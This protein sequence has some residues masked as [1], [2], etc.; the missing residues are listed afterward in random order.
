MDC[1]FDTHTNKENRT[2]P[3]ESMIPFSKWYVK[4][5]HK[6]YDMDEI[7]TAIANITI[8]KLNK[9]LKTK[10]KKFQKMCVFDVP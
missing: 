9:N 8:D 5:Y 2:F 10:A 4:K 7:L 6:K 3:R 1:F